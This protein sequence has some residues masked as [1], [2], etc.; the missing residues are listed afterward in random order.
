[1][2]FNARYLALTR[3]L[4]QEVDPQVQS[5]FAGNPETLKTYDAARRTLDDFTSEI[6]G[7]LLF[8]RVDGELLS[9]V[10]D[11]KIAQALNVFNDAMNA[12]AEAAGKKHREIFPTY[13]EWN[14]LETELVREGLAK[15]LN[16][17]EVRYGPD[18]E[19]INFLEWFLSEA[20]NDRGRAGPGAWE[21]ILRLTPV[22]FVSAGS[23]VASAAQIGTNYYFVE[24]APPKFLKLAGVKNHVGAALTL[25]YLGETRIAHF[26]GKPAVGAVI[27]LDRRE[28]GVSYD[29]EAKKTR[30]TLG[31][32]FQFVPLAF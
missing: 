9:S 1:M 20:V 10:E 11:P 22:Q 8:K 17:Y 24:G 28:I 7:G 18:S 4:M 23:G 12:A 26:K 19:R 21:P 16:S 5:T 29:S 31:Y 13:A 25:Q 6:R 3:Q 15:K 32:S 27:H 2:F 14:R 30:L